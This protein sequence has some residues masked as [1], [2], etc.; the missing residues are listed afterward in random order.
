MDVW[1]LGRI[2]YDLFALDADRPLPEVER[3]SRHVGGSSANLAIGLARLARRVGMIGCVG[4]DLLADYLVS[5]L[6]AEGVDTRFVRRVRGFNTQLCLGEA[7]PPFRQV[8]YRHKPA[9]TQLTVSEAELAALGAARL[10]V[11]NGT[12]LSV[13]PSREATLRALRAARGAGVTTVL[14]VDYR[15][16]S[17]NSAEAA[18][19][20]A[21]GALSAVD[22]VIG[23]EAEIPVLGGESDAQQAVA[24]V[25]ASGPALVV[26]KLGPAGAVAHTR[27]GVVSAPPLQVP[28]ANTVGAGDAFAAGF[29]SAYLD[30]LPLAECLR[31][32]NAAAAIVV[33]RPSCSDAM[34]RPAEIDALLAAGR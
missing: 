9:D 28:V 6:G 21:R 32:G 8:F 3:F 19:Q 10:F 5:V 20:V 25:L 34:P 30:R 17:W 13:E 11:T 16:S 18:G 12:S 23:N 15:S 24:R 22:I 31:Y 26:R 7:Q 29:L 1:V 33:S 4:D 2:A 14:D 27:E